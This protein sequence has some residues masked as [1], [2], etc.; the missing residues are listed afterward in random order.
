MQGNFSILVHRGNFST[1]PST[2]AAWALDASQS[3]NIITTSCEKETF[4][5][6][7]LF[8]T[9]IRPD[10]GKLPPPPDWPDAAECR[11]APSAFRCRNFCLA[12]SVD[13]F[14]TLQSSSK[15]AT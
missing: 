8:V 12:V 9:I 10:A 2:A 14:S 11:C 1:D 13:V 15:E 3:A 5:D 7:L 6:P 4:D